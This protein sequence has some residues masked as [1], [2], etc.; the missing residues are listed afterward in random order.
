MRV[1]QAGILATLFALP[2]GCSND[3]KNSPAPIE[4]TKKEDCKLKRISPKDSSSRIKVTAGNAFIVQAGPQAV[5]P[6][7]LGGTLK[8]ELKGDRILQ[9]FNPEGNIVATFFDDHPEF[10]INDPKVGGFTPATMF[11]AH[12]TGIT[13][14]ILTFCDK[15]G[16]EVEKTTYTIE[17]IKK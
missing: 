5:V 11:L 10:D 8:T 3:I 6:A 13:E 15:D 12:T 16:E 9:R 1:A 14:L 4:V 7:F 2:L 17:V